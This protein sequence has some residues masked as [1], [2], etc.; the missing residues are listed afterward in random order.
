[1]S[2]MQTYKHW[3]IE[4]GVDEILWVYF[5]KQNASVN[6]IDKEVM[7]EFSNIIDTLADDKDH[8]GVIIASGKKNGFIAGADISQFNKFKDIDDATALLRRGQAIFDRLEAL[9]IPVVAMIDGFCVG[10]GLELSLACH[11]RVA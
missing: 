7:E 10:G 3:R 1:M 2:R 11:Y 5:D 9:K 4:T 6:T 8:K